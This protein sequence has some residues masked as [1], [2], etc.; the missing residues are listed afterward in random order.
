MVKNLPPVRETW[1]QSLGWEDPLVHL[2]SAY[3]NR[4]SL[5]AWSR[6]LGLAPPLSFSDAPAYLPLAKAVHVV[7]PRVG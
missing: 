4:P 6:S 2:G 3:R 5:S 1:V 7:E